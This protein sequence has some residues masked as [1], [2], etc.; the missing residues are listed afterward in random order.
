MA[1]FQALP[2]SP[3][4]PPLRG[5]L[6]SGFNPRKNT[7][8]FAPLTRRRFECGTLAFTSK[9]ILLNGSGLN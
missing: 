7:R 5:S 4:T 3:Q 2:L 9:V 8:G 1:V 6:I